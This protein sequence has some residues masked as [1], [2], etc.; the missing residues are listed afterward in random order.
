MIVER[1]VG[2]EVVDQR[3]ALST[4]STADRS[5]ATCC[6]ERSGQE[7]S[8]RGGDDAKKADGSMAKAC[9]G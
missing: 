9:L 8:C 5:Q 3:V 7:T 2:E 6:G 1:L 4:G